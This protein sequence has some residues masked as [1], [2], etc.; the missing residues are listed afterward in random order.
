MTP[1]ALQLSDEMLENSV[2]GAA[3]RSRK[4]RLPVLWSSV[5]TKSPLQIAPEDLALL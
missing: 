2:N 4:L 5:A 1:P 3:F